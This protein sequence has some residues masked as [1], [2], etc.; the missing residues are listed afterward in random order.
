[1]EENGCTMWKM[2]NVAGGLTYRWLID[3][4]L[5]LLFSVGTKLCVPLLT[6]FQLADGIIES[7]KDRLMSD[8]PIITSQIGL[9]CP[10]SLLIGDHLEKL[11]A[12]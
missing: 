4:N 6:M 3:F 10:L 8:L 5:K 12:T 9:I 7:T 1:M 2:N 11:K